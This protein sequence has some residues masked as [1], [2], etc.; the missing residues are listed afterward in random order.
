MMIPSARLAGVPIVIGS[1][2]QLG[3]LISPWRNRVQNTLFRWC[4]RVVCNS[5]AAALRLQQEGVNPARLVVIPNALPQAAFAQ[6]TPAL[7]TIFGGMRVAMISRMNDPAKRHDVFLHAAARLAAKHPKLEFALVGDGDLRAGLEELA[8][9]LGLGN[10]AVFLGERYDIAAVLAS[11]A[12]SVLPSMSE[13]L[14]NSIM[15]SMAAG[16][17]VVACRVGGN[18]ELI[19][20]GENGFLVSPGNAD[21]LADR[22]DQL[23][24]DAELR[25][26]FGAT[27]RKDAQRFTVD[28]IAGEYEK[29]YLSLLEE[30]GVPHTDR[31]IWHVDIPV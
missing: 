29:L 6:A 15:E 30:K 24:R 8:A 31:A 4:D 12:I 18:G 2:R 22:I 17:P 16:V 28:K 14:S 26:S 13:S 5:H 25:Q 10:R 11:S 1:Q 20:D 9:K 19:R 21:E 27:V 7:P 23:V 3:D